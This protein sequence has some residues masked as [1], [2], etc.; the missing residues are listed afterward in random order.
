MLNEKGERAGGTITDVVGIRV[1]SAQDER[2][3]TGCTVVLCSPPAV[4]GVDVRGAAPATRETDL[5][6]PGTLVEHANAIFL[7]GGS[8][9]GLD[10]TAGVMRYLHERG[11]GF[12]TGVIPVPI[13]PAAAIFDLG[14]GE[15]AWP[16]GDMAYAACEVAGTAVEQGSVGAGTGAVVGRMLGPDRVTKGGLG[17]A[18]TR[19]GD[20]TVAALVVVNAVGNVVDPA[21]GAIVAGARAHDKGEYASAPDMPLDSPAI[22]SA[23]VIGVVATDAALDPAA[24]S[25]LATA[26]QDALDRV[27]EPAHTRYDGDTI[28]AL[29]TG[30]IPA[31]SPGLTDALLL[32]AGEAV[33]RA[34][35]NAVLHATTL[36][37]VP[38][39]RDWQP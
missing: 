9:F 20:S 29:S 16:D 2:A 26:G 3:V 28:F 25:A 18:A 22:G 35:L 11:V 38:A 36:G 34:V 21:S 24:T 23:T 5:C 33:E 39:C 30:R 31:G 27:I 4:V 8:A 13:V 19:T 7:T 12:P 32:A 6:R 15:I 37:G 17:S 1:G 10:A 14:I